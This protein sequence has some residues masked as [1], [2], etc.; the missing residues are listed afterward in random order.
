MR[1]HAAMHYQRHWESGAATWYMGR[2]PAGAFRRF[3]RRRES[4]V[5]RQF[6]APAAAAGRRRGRCTPT[7]AVRRAAVLITRMKSILISAGMQRITAFTIISHVGC[8]LLP[9]RPGMLAEIEL[10][11]RVALPGIGAAVLCFTFRACLPRRRL[12]FVSFAGRRRFRSAARAIFSR[13][14]TS[15]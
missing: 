3:S 1:L 5:L 11:A 8:R 2:A 7:P 10:H 14:D 12:H 6:R 4:A 13:A 9:G 15:D